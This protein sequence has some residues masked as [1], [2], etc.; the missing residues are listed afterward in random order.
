MQYSLR[1]PHPPPAESV[2][3][4][5]MLMVSSMHGTPKTCFC[6]H[7]L[8]G[9]PCTV[10]E[11]HTSSGALDGYQQNCQPTCQRT[12]HAAPLRFIYGFGLVWNGFRE[13]LCSGTVSDVYCCCT[14]MRNN[15]LLFS[16]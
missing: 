13:G 7:V 10:V 5:P 8:L 1:A 14:Q 4:A 12:L 16:V 3:H 2:H 9:S 11:H 15:G 6:V